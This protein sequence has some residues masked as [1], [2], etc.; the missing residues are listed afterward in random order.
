MTRALMADHNGPPDAERRDPDAMRAK[1]SHEN[2]GPHLSKEDRWNKHQTPLF[3]TT[4][5]DWGLRPDLNTEIYDYY[6]QLGHPTVDGPDVDSESKTPDLRNVLQEDA[7]ARQVDDTRVTR[8][9]KKGEIA[10]GT[11]GK[12]Y[13]WEKQG[14]D[15]GPSSRMVVKDSQTSNFWH[16][17]HAEGELIRQLNESGCK[18]VVTV[19]EWLYKPASSLHKAFVRTCYEYAEHGDLGDIGL[20][21]RT[22]QLLL[23]EAFLWHIF[24]S[25]ANALC[26]CRHGT[27][28]SDKTM[29]D[30]DT[31]VHGDVKPANMLLTPPNDSVDR[32]YPTIKLCDFGTS[33]T[34]PE[35]IPKVRAWKSTFQYG[36]SGFWAPEVETAKPLENVPGK[37][38]PVAAHRIHGSHSDIYSLGAVMD[39]LMDLRFNALQNHPDFDN[40]HVIDYYSPELR[41]LVKAC[42]KTQVY[43]RPAIYD[44]YRQTSEAMVKWREAALVE[45]ESVRTGRPYQSQVL[46][47][48]AD[49]ARFDNDPGFRHSYR[50][51]NRAPLLTGK[52]TT[53]V[54]VESVKSLGKQFKTAPGNFTSTSEPKTEKALSTQSSAF[55]LPGFGAPE[56][57]NLPFAASSLAPASQPLSSQPPPIPTTTKPGNKRPLQED[58]ANEASNEEEEQQPKRAISRFIEDLPEAPPRPARR[59]LRRAAAVKRPERRVRFDVDV[60]EAEAEEE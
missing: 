56:R 22:R 23:P 13:L 5:T 20:F 15:G 26:Y 58:D 3:H 14:L 34:M 59:T 27:N 25:I 36:T 8:W 44:V 42:R 19:F 47:S 7:L 28:Q 41:A 16:D 45:A 49:R 52:K 40:P 33:F 46:F 37:F 1:A 4:L 6:N 29:P 55:V 24:W 50:K 32:L 43:S 10:R 11:F 48:K 39:Q 57:R 9:V 12:V 17:Y 51:T 2:V 21:Y 54:Q 38:R 35:S 53:P 18:N 60:E 30:W 31:I